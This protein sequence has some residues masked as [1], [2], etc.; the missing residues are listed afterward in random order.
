MDITLFILPIQL[1][2]IPVLVGLN[3][4]WKVMGLTNRWVPLASIVA[5]IGIS[6]AIP[7]TTSTFQIIVGGLVVGLS[8]VGLFSGVRATT[9]K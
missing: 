2:L 3:E 7:D 1:A 4:V 9:G 5:A 8:A 6:F